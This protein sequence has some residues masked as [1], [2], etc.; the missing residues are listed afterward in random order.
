MC[1]II[2]LGINSYNDSWKSNK[3]LLKQIKTSQS[4]VVDEL[5]CVFETMW[6]DTT[7][8]IKASVFYY[9]L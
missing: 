2:S 4:C 8:S 6:L 5:F 9:L 3:V 1:I 7:F